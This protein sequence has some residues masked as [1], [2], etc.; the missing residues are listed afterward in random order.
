[1]NIH[2]RQ[3]IREIKETTQYRK[4]FRRIIHEAKKDIN[5]LD[6]EI[7]KELVKDFF[8][9]LQKELSKNT[10]FDTRGLVPEDE[11]NFRWW[12]K[13]FEDYFIKNY[14]P[15]NGEEVSRICSYVFDAKP[16]EQEQVRYL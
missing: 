9:E 3:T 2:R 1:M 7:P 4:S 16:R 10:L 14:Y 13:Q 5:T 6:K 12:L 11:K 15:N 8:T